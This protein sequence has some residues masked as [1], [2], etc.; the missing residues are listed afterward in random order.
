M[1]KF[2]YFTY[3]H[4]QNKEIIK[5]VFLVLIGQ[6]TGNEISELLNHFHSTVN[7]WAHDNTYYV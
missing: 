3:I 7:A 2:I 5:I 4:T 6:I 1:N